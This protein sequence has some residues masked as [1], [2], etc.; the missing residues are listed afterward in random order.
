MKRID[1]AA[2]LTALAAIAALSSL[3]VSCL[4]FRMIGG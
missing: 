3:I 1:Y 4:T 2:A